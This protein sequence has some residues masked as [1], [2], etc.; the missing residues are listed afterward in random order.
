MKAAS[1]LEGRTDA[2]VAVL[3]VLVHGHALQPL[4]LVRRRSG[5]VT[6][7]ASGVGCA[8][9]DFFGALPPRLREEERQQ[10]RRQEEAM[11]HRHISAIPA[12]H[13]QLLSPRAAKCL[14]CNQPRSGARGAYR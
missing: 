12:K 11:K 10:E 14:G 7:H 4:G 2:R 9:G 13:R 8:G 5:A 3:V 1:D 6:I